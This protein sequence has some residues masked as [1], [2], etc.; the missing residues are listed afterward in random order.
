MRF[1][2]T[3]PFGL[4]NRNDDTGTPQSQV[5]AS[6]GL[7]PSN[8]SSDLRILTVEYLEGTP[9]TPSGKALL[10]LKGKWLAAVFAP[11]SQVYLEVE[12]GRI[13]IRSDRS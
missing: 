11:G 4:R 5:S 3:D 2:V 1:H 10:R 9:Q 6:A 7:A 12:P 8:H 13:V